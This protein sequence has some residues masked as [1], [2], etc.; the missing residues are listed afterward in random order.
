MIEERGR[1]PGP[2]PHLKSQI[3]YVITPRGQAFLANA[4]K[5]TNKGNGNA[6]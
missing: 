5:I 1:R 3:A 2:P 4:Q 6:Q